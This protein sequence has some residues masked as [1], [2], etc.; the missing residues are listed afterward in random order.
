LRALSAAGFDEILQQ[1]GE[2]FNLNSLACY[3]VTFIAVSHCQ[4]GYVHY[5]LTN[6]GQRAWNI[7]IPLLLANETGPE[8]DLLEEKRNSPDYAGNR[9]GQLRYQ[10]DVAS[11]MGDAAYHATSAM[12]YRVRKEMRMAATVYVADIGEDNIDAILNHYTQH[13]PPRDR[14]ELLLAMAGAHWKRDD[15]SAR[16][17]EPLV[18][19]EE[20]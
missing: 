15:P 19:K 7:I 1:I 16:L 2:H 10:Y 11:M 17:P 6:T 9:I 14:P 8:L 5:D 4:R 20:S 18:I 3:H 12:D 13:Y